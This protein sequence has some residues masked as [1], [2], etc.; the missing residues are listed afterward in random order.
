ME[1]KIVDWFLF[2]YFSSL[3]CL[4]LPSLLSLFDGRVGRQKRREKISLFLIKVGYGRRPSAAIEFHSINFTINSISSMLPIQL[5][6]PGEER[7]AGVVVC[8]VL[9]LPS[10]GKKSYWFHWATNTTHSISSIKKKKTIGV[11]GM[12]KNCPWAHNQS[13]WIEMNS[14]QQ[15]MK[16]D[17]SRGKRKLN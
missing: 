9:W 13:L 5:T 2:F 10:L 7:P 1:E 14:F 6:C 8:C 16:R 15:P 12:K 4:S 17:V 11:V 3:R